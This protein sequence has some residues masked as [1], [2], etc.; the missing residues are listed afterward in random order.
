MPENEFDFSNLKPQEVDVRLPNGKDY[1][2]KEAT[3]DA[4][5][6]FRTIQSKGASLSGDG[7]DKTISVG[8]GIGDADSVLLK[9]C[10]FE[11]L[12]DGKLGPVALG[13]VRALPRSVTVKLVL[14]VLSW[15]NDEDE[16]GPKEPPPPT[17]ATST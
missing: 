10:L 8:S 6:E 13:F 11:R 3:E 9:G 12:P 4:F 15:L 1:V 2:L 14:K 7:K 17:S 16:D 5:R